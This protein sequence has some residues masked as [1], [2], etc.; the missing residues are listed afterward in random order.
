MRTF[1]QSVSTRLLSSPQVSN[2]VT[3]PTGSGPYQPVST[4]THFQSR[5]MLHVAQYRPNTFRTRMRLNELPRNTF[6]V[7][8]LLGDDVC[9]NSISVES[10]PPVDACSQL[11]TKR[12]SALDARFHLDS[13]GSISRSIASRRSCQNSM[14]CDLRTAFT[15][16][17]WPSLSVA[18]AS[19]CPLV[20]RSLPQSHKTFSLSSSWRFV[21]KSPALL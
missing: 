8:T 13:P 6:S 2:T 10:P 11:A 14:G 3:E 19:P 7:N 15:T 16:A 5:A 20:Y 18:T 12:D 1:N 21:V 4:S 9:N 17:V